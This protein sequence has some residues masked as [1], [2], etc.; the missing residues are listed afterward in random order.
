[1]RKRHWS[2]WWRRSRLS[3]AGKRE[4]GQGLQPSGCSS[5]CREQSRGFPFP[6]SRFPFPVSRFPFPVSRFPV[7][8]IPTL[9][10]RNPQE[11][12]RPPHGAS[13]GNNLL[14]SHLSSRHS[15]LEP[16]LESLSQGRT[17]REQA[18]REGHR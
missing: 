13:H 15:R 3:K 1:M 11:P 8:Q 9:R 2:S 4:T 7:V 6:V 12:Q 5:S 16:V 18:T 14:G 10:G 17:A